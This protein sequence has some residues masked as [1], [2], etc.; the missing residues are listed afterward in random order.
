I[1]DKF[2]EPS[3]TLYPNPTKGEIHIKF[4]DIQARPEEIRITDLTGRTLK[5]IIVDPNV[6]EVVY[7]LSGLPEGMYLIN[8]G[9][10]TKKLVINKFSD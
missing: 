3:F 9:G 5:E 6:N 8:L 7:T 4:N 2:E 10:E 1:L